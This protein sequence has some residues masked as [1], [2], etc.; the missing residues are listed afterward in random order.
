VNRIRIRIEYVSD[1]EGFLTKLLVTT[2]NISS[3]IITCN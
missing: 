3:S 1:I 2:I